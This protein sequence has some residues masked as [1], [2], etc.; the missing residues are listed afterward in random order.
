MAIIHHKAMK[1]AGLTEKG[2]LAKESKSKALAKKA[3]KKEPEI[4]KDSMG[5]YRRSYGNVHFEDTNK[6]RLEK[7]TK[8]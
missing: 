3:G 6:K 7:R 2:I 5:L 1:A 8:D 4:K